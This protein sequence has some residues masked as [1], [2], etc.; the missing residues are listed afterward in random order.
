MNIVI[1]VSA[2]GDIADGYQFYEEKEKGLGSYFEA[3]IFSDLRSLHLYAGIHQSSF[4]RYYRKVC[5]TFPFEIF[6]RIEDNTVIVYAVLDLRR[7]PDWIS[8]RLN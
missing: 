1:T 5:S 4:A 7:D 8:Q 2:A 6:Y 3:S